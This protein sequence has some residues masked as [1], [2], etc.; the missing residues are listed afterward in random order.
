MLFYIVIDILLY[1]QPG[2]GPLGYLH[3]FDCKLTVNETV[4]TDWIP[5]HFQHRVRQK[6][7]NGLKC[8]QQLHLKLGT[9]I[10]YIYSKFKLCTSI[11]VHL[12]KP[13]K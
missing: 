3:M 11:V 10:C 9:S 7:N 4:T 8:L 1:F 5:I 12:I 2:G 6:E 13:I